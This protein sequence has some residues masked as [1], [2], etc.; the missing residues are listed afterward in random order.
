MI[1][2][3]KIATYCVLGTLVFASK[4]TVS[5][6]AEMPIAG[7]DLLLSD[8]YLNNENANSDI[9]K[10]FSSDLTS[11]YENL[12]F[13]QVTKYVNIRSK[14]NEE[15][16]ILGKLYNNS[17]AKI[18]KKKGDWYKVESGSVT[19]YIKAEYLITGTEAETLAKTIGTRI[20]TVTTTT[21]KVRKDSNTDSPVIALVPI[22]EELI[23][24]KELEGWVKVTVEGGDKGFVSA[25]YVKL[26]TE[27]EEAVSIE[28]EKERLKAEE[29]ASEAKELERLQAISAS[30]NTAGTSSTPTSSNK[31][32]SSFSATNTSS[33][34]SKIVEYALRFEGNS[35]VWGGTSLTNGADCSGFTQSV[36]RDKGISI[37]RTSRSQATGGKKISIDNIQPGDLIF[38]EKRGSI[39]HVALYIGNG[40]V[41]NASSPETG[42]TIRNYNYRQPYKV[43]S[44]IN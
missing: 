7:I 22:E 32:I 28:E 25:D 27:Y 29:E 41:I 24:K 21:L 5:K 35:Y 44:Y 13:A 10:Y 26:H 43:V 39:N 14:S 18:L 12:S 33:S 19:G 20:A 42:I 3:R 31:A 30:N 17:V 40:K 8:L 4:T 38:Y 16:K 23:V 1:K 37:P 6:A 9:T 34:R 36:F 11:E 15:S 2:I